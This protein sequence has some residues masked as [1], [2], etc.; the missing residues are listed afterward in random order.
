MIFNAAHLVQIICF[1]CITPMLLRDMYNEVLV[2]MV[3]EALKQQHS[4]LKEL[5]IQTLI[6][7]PPYL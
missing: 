2:W 5:Q 7:S 3:K 1:T 6:R 4:E